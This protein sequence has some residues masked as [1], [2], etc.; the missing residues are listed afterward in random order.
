MTDIIS[1]IREIIHKS[2]NVYYMQEPLVL[3]MAPDVEKDIQNRLEDTLIGR[4][5]IYTEKPFDGIICGCLYKV[6]PGCKQGNMYVMEKD[7]FLEAYKDE[8]ATPK[9]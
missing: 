7:K 4:A 5:T 1:K 3:V 2:I 9:S 8:L 6:E